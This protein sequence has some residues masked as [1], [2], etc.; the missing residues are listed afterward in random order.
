MAFLTIEHMLLSDVRA[1]VIFSMISFCAQIKVLN[2][3]QINSPEMLKWLDIVRVFGVSRISIK[4]K[5]FRHICGVVTH[6][7]ARLGKTPECCTVY[8][9]TNARI[10]SDDHAM[11]VF[12]K[13]SLL[14]HSMGGGHWSPV[15]S[16]R[17][18]MIGDLGNRGI[19]SG[20]APGWFCET[21]TM[22]CVGT[23]QVSQRMCFS[24]DVCS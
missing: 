1:A 22:I 13:V 7:W 8:P 6:Q 17:L 2:I 18:L 20:S 16:I 3:C 24:V 12:T 21:L 15:P 9:V 10:I 14:G 23:W 11:L 5:C 19:L 4:T